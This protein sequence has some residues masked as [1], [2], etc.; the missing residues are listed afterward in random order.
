MDRLNLLKVTLEWLDHDTRQH[1]HPIFV[2]LAFTDRKFAFL[3][4]EILDSQSE[5]LQ[6]PQAAAIE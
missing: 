1:G 6:Q 3:E 5:G 4:I 2:P